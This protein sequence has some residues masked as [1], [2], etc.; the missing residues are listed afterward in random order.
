[1]ADRT[2]TL[3]YLGLFLSALAMGLLAFFIGVPMPFLLGGVLGSAIFVVLFE[4]RDREL[5]K[6]N[7]YLRLCGISSI[8]A[9]IGSNVSPSLLTL[10]P[11]FWI[12][13]LAILPFIL[14]AHTG[15]YAILRF[16]GGY[17][18]VDAYFAAM[19]GGLVEAVILGEKAGADV[20]VLTVQ[21]FIR[22]L[23][24]V[25]T[26]PMLFFLSTGLVVGSA[27]GASSE[28]QSYGINDIG[29]ILLIALI[30]LFVG[31]GLRL[32]AAHLLGPLVLAVILSISGM[33]S[34]T[35]PPWLLH[36]AQYIVG[37]T[38]G[39]QFS[40][41][42]RSMLRTGFSMGF[43]SVTFMLLLGYGFAMVLAPWVPVEVPALFISFAA[44]GLA[45][46]SLIALSLDLSPVVVAL[47]HLIRIFLTIWVGNKLFYRFFNSE[48]RR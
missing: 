25:V 5:P 20:R 35:V 6:L 47:H 41:I 27:A 30:G 37:V 48:N 14:I 24:I 26:V 46:M 3:T 4:S 39:V 9:M 43:L 29:L 31:R 45:E 42:S 18:R 2:Q 15:S 44:G 23:S 38:L 13:A 22:V 10:L 12:T 32:P 19:P 28:A 33:A 40:G 16:I 1:L 8:G 7:P 36:T 34:I 17:R 21:H 11:E